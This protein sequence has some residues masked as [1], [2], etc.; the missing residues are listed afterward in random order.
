[1]KKKHGFILFG[2]TL[3]VGFWV[4]LM[5]SFWSI[6]EPELGQNL[7][8]G[9]CPKFETCNS[10]AP[11]YVLN[12]ENVYA[13]IMKQDIKFSDIVLRQTII[14]SGHYKSH[15]CKKRNNLLGFK[16]GD[17]TNDNPEGYAIYNN[18]ME[19]IRAYKLWQEKRLTDDISDYYQF[20]IDFKYHQSPDYK[21]KCEG[22]RLIIVKH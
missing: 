6:I 9:I 2:V 16:G 19:S 22:V 7:S 12:Y 3:I 13:E 18:W 21:T 17:K 4:V 5:L 10:F 8:K 11:K 14:E 15:N 1:M 20:L